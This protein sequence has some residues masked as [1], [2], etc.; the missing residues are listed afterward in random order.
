MPQKLPTHTA[1]ALAG[2]GHLLPHVP[3]LLVFFVVS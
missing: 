2:M 3:Q 1:I